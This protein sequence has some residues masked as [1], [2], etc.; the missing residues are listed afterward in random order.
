MCWLLRIQ[1]FHSVSYGSLRARAL[2]PPP[3]GLRRSTR[4]HLPLRV[5]LSFSFLRSLHFCATLCL[6]ASV[7]LIHSFSSSVCLSVRVHRLCLFLSVCLS[8]SVSACFCLSVCLSLCLFA[9]SVFLCLRPS[10]CLSLPL[11]LSDDDDDDGDDDD[12]DGG[13]DDDFLRG[14]S[15]VFSNATWHLCSS[16]C[17][18]SDDKL[19]VHIAHVR[20]AEIGS[21]AGPYARCFRE[22][23]SE[24]RDPS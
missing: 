19:S 1:R 16:F 15:K 9:L 4:S 8:V 7:S 10:L 2:L 13:D 20:L 3:V 23:A 6:D 14:R 18:V 12:D 11:S 5:S 22:G 24:V 21:S 17:C